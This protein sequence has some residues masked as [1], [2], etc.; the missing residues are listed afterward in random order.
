MYSRL[1]YVPLVLGILALVITLPLV[2]S[3]SSEPSPQTFKT[4]A[5]QA[6]V[7]TVSFFPQQGTFG[8]TTTEG[9]PVGIILESNNKPVQNVDF[10]VSFDPNMVQV[11]ALGKGTIFENYVVTQVDNTKGKMVISALNSAIKPVTGIVASFRFQPKK[12]GTAQF[13]FTQASGTEKA[14]NASYLIN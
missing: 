4:E 2:I 8:R 10:V 12:A 7:V 11:S 5:Q 14:L 9:I 1:S 13:I 6:K 3:K